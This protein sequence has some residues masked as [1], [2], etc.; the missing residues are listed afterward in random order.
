MA[1]AR[2]LAEQVSTSDLAQ[3]SLYPP[4]AAIR[5]VSARIAT[6]VAAVA[7]EQALATTPRPAD[8]PASVKAQ[9]YEPRYASL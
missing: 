6:A 2:T 3:G 8:L 9:M 7:Y 4:L 1:A 5:E